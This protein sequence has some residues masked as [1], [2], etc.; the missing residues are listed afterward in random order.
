MWNTLK[1]NSDVGCKSAA[2]FAHVSFTEGFL[3]KA[4]IILHIYIMY[5]EVIL[6]VNFTK[7]CRQTTTR[8]LTRC[9]EY[10]IRM[11]VFILSLCGQVTV[12]VNRV[13]ALGNETLSLLPEMNYPLSVRLSSSKSILQP[14]HVN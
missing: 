4:D 11:H 14:A 13:V 3:E 9:A 7:T 12:T 1:L 8:L 5:K 6:V 10:R 2:Q